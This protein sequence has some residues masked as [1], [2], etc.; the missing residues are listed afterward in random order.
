MDDATF[1]AQK[2]RISCL[3]D[4]WRDLLWLS[5]W[6]VIDHWERV[7]H[8][9]DTED[10]RKTA[11]TCTQWEYMRADVT[12]YLPVVAM[13]PDEEVEELVIHEL[14]HMVVA[15]MAKG[16]HDQHEERVVTHLSRALNAMM[17]VDKGEDDA[18]HQ[19]RHGDQGGDG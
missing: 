10:V 16:K 14:L 4:K 15:E 13:L 19:E 11:E 18:T 7:C 17:K 5:H 3:A 2:R 9:A 6:R 8:K 1:E 12:W